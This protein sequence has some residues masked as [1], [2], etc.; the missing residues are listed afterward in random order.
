[1]TRLYNTQEEIATK[2]KLTLL[3]IIPDIRKTQ[4][5]IIPLYSH[6]YVFI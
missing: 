5:K 4:L 2:I 6:W 1:M 3:D